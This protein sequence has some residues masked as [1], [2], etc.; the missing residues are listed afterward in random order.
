MLVVMRSTI[1]MRDIARACKN[2]DG[3]KEGEKDSCSHSRRPADPTIMRSHD[4][5]ILQAGTMH[6]ERGTAGSQ[7]W[8]G[9]AKKDA[10]L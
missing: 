5:L 3:E 8:G 4:R 10:A 7:A 9:V 1:N 6:L 2:A